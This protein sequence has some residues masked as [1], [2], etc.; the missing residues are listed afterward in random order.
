MRLILTALAATLIISTSASAKPP[1]RDV[2]EIDDVVMAVAIADEIRKSCD[3]INARLVRAYTTI[4]SLKSLAL[5]RGYTEEEVEDYVTSKSE[6][7]RMR[8][9]AEGYLK[10]KGVPL[11]STAALCRFGESEI[12]A[13]TQIGRLLR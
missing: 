1:L 3:G 8:A 2:A 5:E 13:Q 4:N 7:K 9:K 11:G 10:S 6:K 12:A